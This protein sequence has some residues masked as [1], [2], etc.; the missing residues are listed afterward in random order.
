MNGA[1]DIILVI[2]LNICHV[3]DQ[4]L[5]GLNFLKCN[6]SFKLKIESA[7]KHFKEQKMIENYKGCCGDYTPEVIP[8]PL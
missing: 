1:P 5:G 2:F 4:S 7:W 8:Y 3:S 6:L